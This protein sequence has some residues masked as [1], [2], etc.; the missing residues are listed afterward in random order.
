MVTIRSAAVP[1]Q[2]SILGTRRSQV[3][4][5]STTRQRDLV[6][7]QE[8]DT[9]DIGEP[10]R[11]LERRTTAMR[12]VERAETSAHYTMIE[13]R[14]VGARNA[15]DLDFAALAILIAVLVVILVGGEVDGIRGLDALA[16]ARRLA[17]AAGV[18]LAVTLVAPTASARPGVFP[19]LVAAGV[20]TFAA[21][22]LS[23]LGR[24]EQ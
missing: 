15:S 20:L 6:V 13:S 3:A 4:R 22:L 16:A 2:P 10:P 12:V 19:G 24:L 14:P 9:R 23:R 18:R 11:E 8:E 7:T 21:G 5:C 17:V 1:I